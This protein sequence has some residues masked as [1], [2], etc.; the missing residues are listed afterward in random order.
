MEGGE[1]VHKLRDFFR[2]IFDALTVALYAFGDLS[3]QMHERNQAGRD[4]QCIHD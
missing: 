2:G 4:A 3:S 1:L